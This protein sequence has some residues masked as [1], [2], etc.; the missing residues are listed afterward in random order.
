MARKLKPK[1]ERDFNQMVDA[2]YAKW[3]SPR[4]TR[5]AVERTLMKD[6]NDPGRMVL[7]QIAATSLRWGIEG[8]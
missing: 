5:K 8:A 4:K 6:W 1:G 2:I 7:W 3:D